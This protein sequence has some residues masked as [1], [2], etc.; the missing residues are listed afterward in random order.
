M[1]FT[2]KRNILKCDYR[3]KNQTLSCVDSSRDLGVIHDSKLLFDKHI[4]CIV[5]KAYKALGFI[6]RASRSFKNMKTIK[7]LYCAYVRSHLEYASQIWNPCYNV[8]LS[9]IE[10]IQKKFTRF[11]SYK[12]NVPKLEYPQRCSKFHLLPLYLRRDISDVAFLF[13]IAHGDVGGPE[14]LS[15][16]KLNIPIRQLRKP[17]L[18]HIPFSRTQYRKNSF[19]PRCFKL[20]NRLNQDS[21]LD[22]FADSVRSVRTAFIKNLESCP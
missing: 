5:G 18:L 7:I 1:N 2:R 22:L 17:N 21:R 20:F 14:L 9:S 4:Q 10:R 19:F 3:I 13:R 11:L 16:I 8:Y 6:I 15:K 12:F